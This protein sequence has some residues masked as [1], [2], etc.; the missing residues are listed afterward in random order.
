MDRYVMT[1]GNAG[2]LGEWGVERGGNEYEGGIPAKALA[3][4]KNAATVPARHAD[5]P[6]PGQ[7]GRAGMTAPLRNYTNTYLGSSEE[8]LEKSRWVYTIFP[9]GLR[10]KCSIEKSATPADKRFQGHHREG[11]G[12]QP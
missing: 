5:R 4:G 7:E 10:P 9:N 3:K 1:G 6:G 11:E 8:T 2:I 12:A